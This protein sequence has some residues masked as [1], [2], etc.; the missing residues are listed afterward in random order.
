MNTRFNKRYLALVLAAVIWGFSFVTQATGG[1]ALGPYAFNTIRFVFSALVLCPLI[2]FMDAKGLSVNKPETKEEKRELTKAGAICGVL[3]FIASNIQQV[4]IYLGTSP[5]KAGFLTACYIVFVPIFSIFTGKKNGINVWAAIGIA[6][7]GLYF[8]CLP[9]GGFSIQLSDI[10]VLICAVCFALQIMALDY[11][12]PRVDGIRL[13]RLE[14]LWCVI[15]GALPVFFLDMGGSIHGV[16]EWSQ[17]L[18]DPGAWIALLYSGIMSGGGGYTLQIVGQ[19][20]TNPTI[21]GL[22]MSL[23]SVFSVV[24]EWLLLHQLLSGRELAGCVLVF[25]AVILTQLPVGSDKQATK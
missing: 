18:K 12:S 20:N 8:L 11:Y 23:E 2:A 3:L 13:A 9:K 19:K 6:I 25:T 17:C 4:G 5:G 10:L 24:G 16:I 15:L 7:V 21:A 22:L 14:F 1:D